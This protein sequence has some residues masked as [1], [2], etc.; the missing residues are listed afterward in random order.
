M[1]KTFASAKWS[2][3]ASVKVFSDI[4][5]LW[6]HLHL[7]FDKLIVLR[8]PWLDISS[9]WPTFYAKKG[10]VR[11]VSFTV[12]Y[13]GSFICFSVSLFIASTPHLFSLHPHWTSSFDF[14]I[15]EIATHRHHADRRRECAISLSNSHLYWTSECMYSHAFSSNLVLLSPTT[16]FHNVLTWGL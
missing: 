1:I 13:R 6:F 15:L 9:S 16:F 3:I 10:P 7:R 5:K 4:Q 2:Q 8:I 11:S 14:C 12:T